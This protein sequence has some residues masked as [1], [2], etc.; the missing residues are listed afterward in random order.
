METQLMN[1]VSKLCGNELFNVIPCINGEIPDTVGEDIANVLYPSFT[2]DFHFEEVVGMKIK[3]SPDIFAEEGSLNYVHN[4]LILARYKAGNI[5]LL[6]SLL[7]ENEELL[8]SIL[9]NIIPKAI[10]TLKEKKEHNFKQAVSSAIES[11]VDEYKDRIQSNNSECE[12]L[13]DQ[14]RTTRLQIETD[15]QALTALNGTKGQWKVKAEKEYRNLFHL[16]PNMYSAF[17][18]EDDKLIASTNEVCI[19]YDCYEYVIGEFDIHIDLKTGDLKIHNTTN[20]VSGY[21]HPHINKGNPCLGNIADGLIRM[22]TEFELFGAL[23]M[24][25]NYLHSYNPDSVYNKIEFWNPDYEDNESGRYESCHEDNSGYN[26]VECGDGDCPF[27]ENAYEDC[28]E[29]A[30]LEDC[31]DCHYQCSFGRERIKEHKEEQLE[32]QQ[33]E[34][35]QS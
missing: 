18:I 4:G 11:R 1:V 9:K 10:E 35:L 26:C 7:D 12:N 13:Q 20:K 17:K 22:I 2:K 15:T 14:I 28:N 24:I 16:I 34:E 5:Y 29:Y 33:Q 21:D 30:S 23:Q 27:Y 25:Y 6:F 31:I 19:T 3:H 8:E 32:L